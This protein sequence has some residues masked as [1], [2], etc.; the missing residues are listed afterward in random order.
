MNPLLN[1]ATGP[2]LQAELLG[3]ALARGILQIAQAE[4]ALAALREKQA[5]REEEVRQRATAEIG[6]LL[7]P[8][9]AAPKIDCELQY[10]QWVRGSY[11]EAV[12]PYVDLRIRL[13]ESQQR[14]ERA[15]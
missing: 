7:V 9:G 2:Q 12:L 3:R 13:L 15:A 8:P 11:P 14:K 5:R 6:D 4:T 10:W 1:S